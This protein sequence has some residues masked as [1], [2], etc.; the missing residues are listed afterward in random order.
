MKKKKVEK[1]EKV[2]KGKLPV[3]VLENK[4]TI[5]EVKDGIVI[6]K[7]GLKKK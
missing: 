6:V 1:V 2:E 4:G 3:C 7:E 5:Q